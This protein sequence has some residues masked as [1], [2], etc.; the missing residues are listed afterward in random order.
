MW[1]DPS[2]VGRG[3]GRPGS[4]KNSCSFHIDFYVTLKFCRRND[5]DQNGSFLV[6]AFRL[7]PPH[8]FRKWIF[9]ILRNRSF[10][11]C[12]TTGYERL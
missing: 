10:G 5:G 3:G 8:F 12:E 9:A 1:M 4:F 6:V 11:V 2:I 7:R